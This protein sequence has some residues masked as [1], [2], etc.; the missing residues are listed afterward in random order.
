M[1][2]RVV[3]TGLGS[4]NAIG[5]NVAETW[6]S[7]KNG[8]NGIDT[9]SLFDAGHMKV[10]LAG[11]VKNLNIKDY[12]NPKEARKM[13]RF[14]Q[15]GMIA[16]LEAYKDA[17]LNESTINTHRF[18]VNVSSGIGGL[19]TIEDNYQKGL[20][21]GF[22]RVS[23]FFIPMAISNLASGQ[24]A[25]AIKAQGMA[26]CPVTACAGGTNAIGEAFRI[27]RDG[28]LDIMLAGG[29]ESSITPLGIGGFTAMKA[30]SE[31]HDK[32]R[33]SI[34]FDAQRHGFVMG[35]GAGILILEELEH[36][37]K[38]NASIYAEIIGYGVSCDA[39][40][41]TAPSPNGEGGAYAMDNALKDA[42]IDYH[43]IDYINAHGT[44]TLLNDSGETAAI[45][46]VFKEHAKKLFISST[47]GNTG[48]C[49]GAAGGIEAVICIKAL[50]NNYVPA[51]INYQEKDP[52][53]DLNI[54]PNKGQ[55]LDMHYCMSNSLGFGGH[56]ASIIFK[57]YK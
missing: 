39:Y 55:A 36:A 37:L 53:C 4:I 27:I 11:E 6:E 5:H 26:S 47:K 28:Y 30:L 1:K 8:I 46:T 45:K 9:I 51:T 31:S 48:H 43:D 16:S 14:T 32:N 20:E 49:L 24:I 19:K 7:I 38:R 12:L 10:Q 13:D 3:V 54:T 22:D 2:R 44:S 52:E 42:D 21:K 23:P 29:C 40:H 41:M 56:N 15:L 25:I 33:A 17:R 18:G 35:E 34:P 57:E 50:E